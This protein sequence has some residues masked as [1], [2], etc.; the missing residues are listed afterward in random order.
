[1]EIPRSLVPAQAAP[2]ATTARLVTTIV[3]LTLNTAGAVWFFTLPPILGG[4]FVRVFGRE[5]ASFLAAHDVAPG[6]VTT[7]A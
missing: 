5:M 1:M 3:L 7:G 2:P 6:A 4:V